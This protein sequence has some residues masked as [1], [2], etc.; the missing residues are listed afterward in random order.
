MLSEASEAPGVVWSASLG[1]LDLCSDWQ[2]GEGMA[3]AHYLIVGH[4]AATDKSS[5][6]WEGT[7]VHGS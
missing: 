3:L 5:E 6:C 4:T 2:Q 7:A 1:Q